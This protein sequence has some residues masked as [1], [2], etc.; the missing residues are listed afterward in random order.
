[1][2]GNRRYLTNLGFLHMSKKLQGS[3]KSNF[4]QTTVSIVLLHVGALLPTANTAYTIAFAAFSRDKVL[5]TPYALLKSTPL[6][7]LFFQCA[8]FFRFICNNFRRMRCYFYA[9]NFCISTVPTN[10]NVNT[11]ISTH[12]FFSL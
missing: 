12:K 8:L 11:K 2:T 9:N 3:Q 1:M 7:L 5:L 6:P 10:S 4:F